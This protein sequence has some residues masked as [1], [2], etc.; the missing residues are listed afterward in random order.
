MDV[1]RIPLVMLFILIWPCGLLCGAS[2][3]DAY[4]SKEH[5]PAPHLTVATSEKEGPMDLVTGRALSA[6][7]V[8]LAKMQPVEPLTF[9]EKNRVVIP[10]NPSLHLADEF[11]IEVWCKPKAGTDGYALLKTYSFGFPSFAGDGSV[12]WYMRDTEKGNYGGRIPD[13]CKPNEWQ[14][15]ALTFGA[16]RL[17]IYHSGKKVHERPL[18]MRAGV[19]ANPVYVG[20]SDG[21]AG[22]FQGQIG[23]ARIYNEALSAEFI[24]SNYERLSHGKAPAQSDS[25]VLEAPSFPRI[26]VEKVLQFNGLDSVIRV[27]RRAGFSPRRGLMLGAWIRP[28]GAPGAQPILAN[29]NGKDSGYQLVLYGEQL[30]AILVT[31]DGA[32]WLRAPKAIA[33]NQWQNVGLAWNG[34]TAQLFRNGQPIGKPT[35]T[36]GELIAHPGPLLIGSDAETGGRHY[37]GQMADARI[38]HRCLVDMQDIPADAG[39]EVT[40][41][42]VND[43]PGKKPGPRSRHVEGK[44]ERRKPLVDF[45]D[46]KGWKCVYQR[47]VTTAILARSQEQR[48]WG[49]YVAKVVVSGDKF[50]APRHEVRILPPKPIPIEGRFDAI[51]LWAYPRNWGYSRSQIGLAVRVHVRDAAGK[52]HAY[53]LET[54]RW[55]WWSGWWIAH[56]KL[57][58]TFG[59]GAS[60]TGFAIHG[61]NLDR[62]HLLYLDS[63]SFYVED[64]SPVPSFVPDWDELPFPTTRDTILPSLAQ[65]T[66]YRNELRRE[67]NRVSLFYRSS[68]GD[69]AVEWRYEPRSGTLSDIEAVH[70]KT[71]FRPAQGGGLMLEVSGKEYEADDPNITKRLVHMEVK[72]DT[73]QTEWQY[74][75]EG[76]AVSV[77]LDVTAKGKSLIVDVSADTG[78]VSEVRLGAYEGPSCKLLRVPF[79]LL[80]G[81]AHKSEGPAILYTDKFFLSA[82]CDWYNSNA[83]ELF[84]EVKELG[85]EKATYNGGAA[86]YK[87]SD[88][89]RNAVRER[90]FFTVSDKFAEV[91]PNIPNPPSPHIETTRNAVWITR[92]WYMTQATYDAIREGKQPGYYEQEFDF[93]KKVHDYG[94]RNLLIRRHVA[95]WR[96][97]LPMNGDPYTLVTTSDPRCGGDDKLAEWIRKIQEQLGYCIGLY[98]NYTLISPLSYDVWDENLVT[99]NSNGERVDGS[100]S[101]FM[102]KPSRALPLQEQFATALKRKFNPTCSYQ[103]Q[104]TTRPIWGCVDYDPRVE[105]AGTFGATFRVHGK[106]LD[107][108]RRIYGGPVLSEGYSHWMFA[109]LA[110]AN[111]AQSPGMNEPGIVDFQLLRIHPL[112]NDCG[113]LWTCDKVDA[114]VAYELLHGVIGHIRFGG[115]PPQK[116]SGDFLKCIFMIR[117][118]QPYFAGVRVKE[119]RYADKNG[120]L[121][122]TEGAIRADAW[123]QGRAKVTYE[124]GLT[125]HVNRGKENWEV[126][127]PGGEV[128][129]PTNGYLVY[130]PGKLYGY[131]ALVNG[132]RVDFMSN[133]ERTYYD[134]RGKETNFGAAK[135]RYAY[136]IERD[137]KDLWLV[138]APYQGEDIVSLG[139]GAFGMNKKPSAEVSACDASGKIL[140][141]AAAE[142]ADG[143]LHVKIVPD[144]FKYRIR[145]R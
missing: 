44:K 6:N 98:S 138:P 122:T 100:L 31:T 34:R 29:G 21:W 88:G 89:K 112:E 116:V 32:H 90:I 133:P 24:R 67:G 87:K 41:P 131:S 53:D 11:S 121:L 135:A 9:G 95:L 130:V 136:V 3:W 57:P 110:D 140:R 118:V 106:L 20:F 119:I 145:Q 80:R 7:R 1:K 120:R 22:K 108:E 43:D 33:K 96:Q 97:Y 92:P 30:S 17:A 91:L 76:K 78:L 49:D 26:S 126:T 35:L 12:G 81:H 4:E 42:A 128:A 134:G 47:G 123:K 58:R 125:V 39:E 82:F 56:R 84:G 102:L 13:V 8:S 74:R 127:G 27:P 52:E 37:R 107:E 142:V 69:E 64:R 63:L 101:N 61:F 15:Y 51:E 50:A 132:S 113:P 79:L 62:R 66:P 18:P 93:W 25:M 73:L 124:S 117:E 111:Y 48:M 115:A 65:R 94:V 60:F 16:Q 59:P 144:V 68:R 23:L 46:M 141:H 45:E 5:G 86:Y 104:I 75:I 137:K 85:T 10:D 83:S 77:H 139:M 103:D 40:A 2:W 28:S 105:G 129:L 19:N 114:L 70:N 36:A 14:H 99:L 54:N 72:G 38:F 143:S 109:G 71:R 55:F